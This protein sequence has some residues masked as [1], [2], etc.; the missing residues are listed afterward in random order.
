MSHLIVSQNFVI[1]SLRLVN[2]L[3]NAVDKA[4]TDFRTIFRFETDKAHRKMKKLIRDLPDEERI[5]KVSEEIT[6][7]VGEKSTEKVSKD[8]FVKTKTGFIDFSTLAGQARRLKFFRDMNNIYKEWNTNIRN[9]VGSV[10]PGAKLQ[11]VSLGLKNFKA[12][13]LM[14]QWRDEIVRK[15]NE[16]VS[17]LDDF[18][19]D[20]DDVKP[21]RES[22]LEAFKRRKRVRTTGGV[23]SARLTGRGLPKR[24]KSHSRAT[25]II[26]RG[27]K[28]VMSDQEKALLENTLRGL[29]QL[30]RKHANQLPRV[31]LL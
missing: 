2:G 8:T 22:L 16:V 7:R 15:A 4:W 29:D 27:L 19:K 5:E 21:I 12:G 18:E 13:P 26:L 11:E 25:S 14:M 31:P 28:D 6:E 1:R 30:P 10:T 17:L 24:S 3:E 9:Q 23:I 20:E